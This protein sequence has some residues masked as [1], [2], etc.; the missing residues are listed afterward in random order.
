MDAP[1]NAKRPTWP[2][3]QHC[4]HCVRLLVAAFIVNFVV[5]LWVLAFHVRGSARSGVAN[6]EANW[7]GRRCSSH[8]CKETARLLK[9]FRSN[10]TSPCV[11]FYEHVCAGVQDTPETSAGSAS[12]VFMR[13]AGHHGNDEHRETRASTKT[14]SAAAECQ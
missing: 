1:E 14:S 3:S 2:K 11:D 9:S 6:T 5:L 8:R 13:P 10:H 12:Q 4:H 7:S